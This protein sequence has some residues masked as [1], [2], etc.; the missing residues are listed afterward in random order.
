MRKWSTCNDFPNKIAGSKHDFVKKAEFLA[1]NFENTGLKQGRDDF[2]NTEYLG[3]FL[4]EYW[5]VSSNLI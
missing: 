4:L 3:P 5:P 1:G 2:N